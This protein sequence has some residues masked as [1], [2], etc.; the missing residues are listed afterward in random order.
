MIVKC[1][2]YGQNITYNNELSPNTYENLMKDVGCMWCWLDRDGSGQEAST[3]N[4]KKAGCGDFDE[5]HGAGEEV[6]LVDEKF[7][8]EAGGGWSLWQ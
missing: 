2:C 4:R 1:T 8:A 6:Y 3:W 5:G 7:A